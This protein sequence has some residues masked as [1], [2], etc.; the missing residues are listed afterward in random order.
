MTSIREYLNKRSVK[1]G[2]CRLW[3]LSTDDDGYGNASYK[4]KRIGAHRLSW[5]EANGPIPKGMCVCHTCDVRPCIEPTHL[6]LGSNAD[7]T[8][9]RNIKGRTS[10]G[11]SH[12]LSFSSSQRWLDSLPIGSNHVNSKVTEQQVIA[13]REDRRPQWVIGLDYGIT[14]SA[15]SLIKRRK[16]WAHVP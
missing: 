16:L 8:A 5:M 4:G 7:N 15:V 14:Q 11:H 12:S 10:K 1:S 6:W 2:M 3:S 13:I 9:D